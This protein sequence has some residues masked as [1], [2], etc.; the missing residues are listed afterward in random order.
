MTY[1]YWTVLQVMLFSFFLFFFFFFFF[2]SILSI[3]PEFKEK[4]RTRA[5]KE[6][7]VVGMRRDGVGMRREGGWGWRRLTPL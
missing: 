2:E 6:R 3:H 5:L 4:K 7:G 1:V